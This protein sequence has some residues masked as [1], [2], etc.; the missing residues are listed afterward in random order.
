ME[1]MV[2]QRKRVTCLSGGKGHIVCQWKRV[3]FVSSEKGL[4][5]CHWKRTYGVSDKKDWM[6]CQRKR[7]TYLFWKKGLI[8]CQMKRVVWHVMGEGPY[9][10]SYGKR[11]RNGYIYKV[12]C[13]IIMIHSCHHITLYSMFLS[14]SGGM[15]LHSWICSCTVFDCLGTELY[16]DQSIS[17]VHKLKSV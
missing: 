9:Y 13:H 17:T 12:G 10:M 7:A 15:H 3:I 1:C 8:M 4:M 6:M 2:C 11:C 14:E 5:L 16:S